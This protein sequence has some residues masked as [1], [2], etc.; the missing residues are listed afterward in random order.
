MANVETKPVGGGS[1]VVN[2]GILTLRNNESYTWLVGHNSDGSINMGDYVMATGLTLCVDVGFTGALKVDYFNQD[3]GVYQV[4]RLGYNVVTSYV[5]GYTQLNN[6]ATACPDLAGTRLISLS[7][8][9]Y[10]GA[11]PLLLAV[12]PIRGDT[13]MVVI[14]SQGSGGP[15][16]FPSQGEEIKSFGTAGDITGTSGA[17]V[18]RNVRV[19]NQYFVPAFDV[20]R[21]NWIG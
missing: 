8:L 9:P 20:G 5:D 11:A 2:M 12:K 21:D 16:I 15:A 18:N 7:S 4:T 19:I 1:N 14:A 3:A 17:A 10:W 13:H 6:P